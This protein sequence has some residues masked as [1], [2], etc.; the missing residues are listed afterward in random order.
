MKPGGKIL[1]LLLSAFVSA[2][3]LSC[4]AHSESIDTEGEELIRYSDLLSMKKRDD[5][6]VAVAI[7]NPW[8]TTAC[9][10]RYI[11]VDG[12]SAIEDLPDGYERIDVPVSSA[13]VYSSVHATPIEELGAASVIKGIADADYFKSPLI[14]EK[15]K[16]GQIVDVGSSMSPSIE[17][18]VA[19]SPQIALVSPYE[20][21][22]H[23]VLEN[24]GITVVDMADY[25]ESTPLGR[26]EWLLF[27]GALTGHIEDSMQK[28]EMTAANY[29]KVSAEARKR[30]DAPLVLTEVPYKGVWYQPGG[31]S[32]MAQLIRDA[33]GMP[34][35]NSVRSSGSVQTDIGGV[36]E[37]GI[38]ADVWLIKTEGEMSRDD[39]PSMNPLLGKIKAYATGNVWVV[40]TSEVPLYDMLA[41]HP[42]SVLEDFARIF[43]PDNFDGAGPRFYKKL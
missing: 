12:T 34:L 39:L 25:M 9:L 41:F 18:I 35:F 4:G 17:K 43:V 22:G 24:T 20:N 11:L 5:G 13:L 37:K 33:G 32:Y 14:L 27:I 19:L 16:N 3:L 29:E 8:D 38:D 28:F 15:T 36:F 42:D 2:V 1:K 30:G 23:G 10:A 6:T 21:S 7:R 40:N 31:G 26:A